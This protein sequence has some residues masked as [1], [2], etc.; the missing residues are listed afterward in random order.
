MT[1]SL[2]S[3]H[4]PLFSHSCRYVA[5]HSRDARALHCTPFWGSIRQRHFTLPSSDELW[6]TQIVWCGDHTQPS[7]AA[8]RHASERYGTI[9]TVGFVIVWP[10][11]DAPPLVD[12]ETPSIEVLATYY[13]LIHGSADPDVPADLRAALSLRYAHAADRRRRDSR[14]PHPVPLGAR[15]SRGSQRD[16]LDQQA[17]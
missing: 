13:D 17:R 5:R 4:T 16:P 10:R 15:R 12:G 9:Q 1:Q 7:E 6:S 11:P 14:G 2:Y 3:P 8:D